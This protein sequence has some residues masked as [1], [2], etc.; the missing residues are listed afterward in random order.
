MFI[1]EQHKFWFDT[2]GSVV[3]HLLNN[4]NIQSAG[5]KF[6]FPEQQQVFRI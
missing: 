1:Q 3:E 2:S 6:L 4:R 5:V